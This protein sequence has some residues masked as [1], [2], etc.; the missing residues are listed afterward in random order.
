MARRELTTEQKAQFAEQRQAELERL[1]GEITAKATEISAGPQ[2]QAW[3]QTAAKFHRY[4]FK[5]QLL[6]M[7]QRPDA[8][9]VAGFNVW[10]DSFR[11]HVNKGE[12]GIRILAPVTK[13]VEELDPSGKPVIVDG[14]PVRDTRMIGVKLVSVFDVSQTNGEPLPQAPAPQLL[15]G[16]APA[17]LW[18]ALAEIV[19]NEG[20]GLERGDCG[21][22]NG[23]TN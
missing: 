9:A 1:Q 15:R 22:A 8:T 7:I 11:R 21:S 16:E 6:I 19:E 12:K 20:F 13:R 3:L 14:K 4:S 10:R 2:W 23:W 5:N 17:G 18:D